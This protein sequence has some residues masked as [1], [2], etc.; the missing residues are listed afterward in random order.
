MS[1]HRPS[2]Q[3]DAAD[4]LTVNAV[5]VDIIVCVHNALEDVHRCL[6]SVLSHSTLTYHLILIDDGS[7]PP[8]ADYLAHF[9]HT[10]TVTLARN[11][12]ARGYTFAANQGLRLSTERASRSDFV[13]LLNSDTIVTPFWLENLVSC[14]QTASNIGI[15][16]PLSNTASW[17]S[18]PYIE[19]N[20]DWATNP[21]P[22]DLT[23]TQ[24][25]NR[26][27]TASLKIYPRLPF[28][29][30]FCLLIKRQLIEAIGYFDEENFGQGYGEENDYCL[31]ARAAGWELALADDTYIFHA[32][33]KSYSHE[34]RKMLADRA[35]QILVAKHGQAIIDQG[36]EFCRHSRVLQAIRERAQILIERWNFIEQAR[37]RFQGKRILF[38]LPVMEA[39]GGAN[40]VL[41]EVRV[42]RKMGIDAQILN[43]LH[44]QAVFE[45]SYPHLD[46][47]VLYTP[48]DF[49]IPRY[50]EGFDVVVATANYSIEWLAPAANLPNPP[51]IA[52]Y[53]QDFEP[54]FYVDKPA[55]SRLF[56]QSGWLRRRLASYYF[57]RHPDFRRA[58]LSYLQIP[59]CLL[60]TKTTWC[61]QEVQKQTGKN[62][63]VIGASVDVDL[64]H[65][66]LERQTKNAQKIVITAMIRPSSL[67]RGALQTMRVLRAIQQRY[68]QQVE[69]IT[70][71]VSPDDPA[72]LAL[73]RDFE[74]QHLGLCTP[75]QIAQLFNQADIFVDFS[76]F[77]AMGLTAMEAMS[78]GLA[79]IA[80]DIGGIHSFARHEYNVL[81]VNTTSY[82]AC[83]N[84]VENLV[85]NETLRVALMS[86]ARQSLGSFYP[87]KAAYQLLNFLF[88]NE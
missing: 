20:G 18:I 78:C 66:R 52:Y 88:T 23:V 32:Q 63:T 74:F 3:L 53:I 25:A 82:Q 46:I 4:T 11:E 61:Q 5:T 72:F 6:E 9:A 16:G 49:D 2:F 70:F 13:I 86:Q 65:P 73:P 81:L 67:R 55:H 57:R 75:E 24:M 17:Q 60:F 28:L 54:Y 48:T 38:M 36:V 26:V 50:C 84:S 85:C 12:I 22:L 14:A 58:W 37:Y 29:N 71:G 34:R 83:Y 35:F 69:I 56:W 7:Q 80:P 76:L 30:G 41:S 42:L 62:C 21:L 8:T 1:I 51:K 31:R 79:V 64:F 40:V 47:P 59:N 44:H 33:S 39:G 87:E 10:H 15:V 19:Q 68:A 27:R 43:F 77:Q 45:K